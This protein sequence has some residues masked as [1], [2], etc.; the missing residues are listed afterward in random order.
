MISSQW[1]TY[2]TLAQGILK[3]RIEL[4]RIA[5]Y[6]PGIDALYDPI[7]NAVQIHCNIDHN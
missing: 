5:G 3:G 7:E 1:L 2:G 6:I 4:R